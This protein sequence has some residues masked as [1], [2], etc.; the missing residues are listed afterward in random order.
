MNNAYYI[1]NKFY[2][3]NG[4]INMDEEMKI[5]K[6]KKNI[7]LDQVE[8]DIL[9]LANK[10]IEVSTDQAKFPL[11]INSEINKA[12]NDDYKSKINEKTNKFLNKI[13]KIIYYNKFCKEL[14]NFDYSNAFIVMRLPKT[15]KGFAFRFLKIVFNSRGIKL[16]LDNTSNT[17]I[18]LRAYLIFV[19]I[20][21]QNN[22][23]KRCFNKGAN[24]P[25]INI[26]D[27]GER[28]LIK[29][30]FGEEMIKN[31]LNLDQA[32]FILNLNNWKKSI[33]VFKNDFMKIETG[34]NKESILYLDSEYSSFC[35]HSKLHA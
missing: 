3:L 25:K 1:I 4:Q 24:T 19:I 18:L 28:D 23:I 6:S 13:P 7:D 5:I 9:K 20:H 21:E 31:N 29:I 22:F 35:D 11:D 15:I 33:I 17:S 16:N 34:G 30:L 2:L 12:M 8:L 10:T 26:Y 27:E 32:K 14:K